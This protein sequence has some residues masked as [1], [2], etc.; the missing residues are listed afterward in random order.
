MA[1]PI[2][3]ASLNVVFGSLLWYYCY[4]DCYASTIDFYMESSGYV[5]VV[6]IPYFGIWIYD[7]MNCIIN[8]CIQSFWKIIIVVVNSIIE[9]REIR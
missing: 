6:A 5:F 2:K 9:F 7:C 3:I 1:L 8:A 4:W